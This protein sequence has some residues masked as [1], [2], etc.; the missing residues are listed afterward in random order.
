MGVNPPP[1]TDAG[2]VGKWHVGQMDGFLPGQRGF[3]SYLGIPVCVCVQSVCC[4]VCH[5]LPPPWSL[6][7]CVWLLEPAHCLE[8]WVG[9]QAVQPR[10]SVARP[11]APA[12]HMA[13]LACSPPRTSTPW[14]WARAG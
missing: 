1:P 3:D 9:T 10:G 7:P 6:L 14:T 8:L 13:S 5:G 11:A 2:M 12:L 4:A